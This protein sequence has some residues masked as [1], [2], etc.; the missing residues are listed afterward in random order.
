MKEIQKLKKDKV[1]L[2]KNI[3]LNFLVKKNL[4]IISVLVILRIYKI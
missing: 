1:A 3:C 4:K 2:L